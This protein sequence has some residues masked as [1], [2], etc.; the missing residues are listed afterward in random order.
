MT[1]PDDAV[2]PPEKLT[3]YLLVPRPLDDKSKFLARAGFTAENP[4]DLMAELRRLAI[5]ADGVE[6]GSNAYGTFFQVEGEL[7]GPGR[8]SLAVV[9]VWL[10]WHADGS[11]HFV[12]L[13]PSRR[14][15]P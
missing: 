5:G 6:D 10:R 15:H 12:T 13:K 14:S 7:V 3:H 8:R 4:D 1:I 11:F 9:A 2:I